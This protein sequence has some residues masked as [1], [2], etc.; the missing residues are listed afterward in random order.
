MEIDDGAAAAGGQGG[1]AVR[2]GEAMGEGGVDMP[3][4]GRD[5]WAADDKT[6]ADRMLHAP[7]R[8]PR[9]HLG[10]LGVERDMDY[11][12]HDEEPPL[13]IQFCFRG[14]NNGLLVWNY[15]GLDQTGG[16][17]RYGL[18][19]SIT[20][21][22]GVAAELVPPR[23][24]PTESAPRSS[25][26]FVPATAVG[27]LEIRELEQYRTHT[28][29]EPSVIKAHQERGRVYEWDYERQK[30]LPLELS[31]FDYVPGAARKTFV[32]LP[33]QTRQRLLEEKR[34]A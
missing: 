4:M 23:P 1:R 20:D 19:T 33:R 18:S 28:D 3:P 25:I 14:V 13:E 8:Y 26:G 5:P 31:V 7:L 24:Y 27:R 6:V 22:P 30:V 2:D 10:L 29:E 34:S 11:G 9:E 16:V 17:Q 12:M 32:Q 21:G 15:T